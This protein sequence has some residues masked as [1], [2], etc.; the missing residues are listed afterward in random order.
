MKRSTVLTP[1]VLV[2]AAGAAFANDPF[3]LPP[4]VIYSEIPGDPTAVCPGT[5]GIEFTAFLDLHA[6]FDGN[7]WV[8]KAFINDAENDVIVYGNGTSATGVLAAWE[9]HPTALGNGT[10]HNFLDSDCGINDNGEYCYGSRLDGATSTTDEIILASDDVGGEFAAFLES[11]PAAGLFDSGPIGDE[12]FGNSLNS[13]SRLNDGT[14]NCKA[15]QIQNIASAYE[16]ALYIG[17]VPVAQEG[18]AVGDGNTYGGFI[19]L[20]GDL[21]DTSADGSSWIVE[22]DIDPAAIGTIEAVVVDSAVQIQDGDLLPGASDVVDAVFGVRMTGSGDWMARGDIPGDDDWAVFNFA[23]RGGLYFYT[24]DPI[25]PGNEETWGVSFLGINADDAGNYVIAGTTSNPDTNLDSVIVMNGDT[26]ISREGDAVD[27]DGNGMADDDVEIA[28]YSPN[29]LFINPQGD[30][31]AF[32][33]L[34][35]TSDGTALG[36]AF[37]VIDAPGPGGP[38]NGA[39]LAL[40]FEQLDFSDVILFL[41][42]FADADPKVDYAAPFGIVDF[43][44]VI[45]FLLIFSAGCP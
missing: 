15:D 27:L 4:R 10:S 41:I 12:A 40:P 13:P 28:S 34:R 14:V 8:F 9:A 16:S 20:T 33:T 30:V 31:I 6:S 26:V 18:V 23:G 1:S 19:G 29:D 38:C 25:T 35:R 21:F 37:V 42:L 3:V 2:I 22:A 7:W 17:S 43:S 36:D 24:G 39:D 45:E 11:E 44:D 5:G 32:V